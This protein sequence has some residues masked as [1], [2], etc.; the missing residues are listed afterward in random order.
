MTDLPSWRK[1]QHVKPKEKVKKWTKQAPAAEPTQSGMQQL[2]TSVVTVISS[3]NS[4]WDEMTESDTGTTYYWNRL[5]GETVQQ[6]P[7][8]FDAVRPHPYS[9]LIAS[10][11]QV[12]PHLFKM[13][14]T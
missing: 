10:I 8:D 6:R 13:R 11:S 3:K 4:S 14:I 9:L 12:L 1:A 7:A 5:T 2:P